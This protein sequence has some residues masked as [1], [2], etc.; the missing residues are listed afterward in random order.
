MQENKHSEP[1]PIGLND[2]LKLKSHEK[3]S[4]EFWTVFEREYKEKQL[5]TLVVRES[6]LVLWWRG[7]FEKVGPVLP[8]GA[9]AIFIFGIFLGPIASTTTHVASPEKVAEVSYYPEARST[10]HLT[11]NTLAQDLYDFATASTTYVVGT[12]G[13]EI[14]PAVGQGVTMVPATRAMPASN[15]NG[16]RYASATFPGSEV[17]QVRSQSVSAVY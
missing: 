13:G 14:R 17:G 8:V 6:H 11:G 7:F 12:L 15:R 5:R 4:P 9:A 16:V 10:E 3:P 2:L 1:K